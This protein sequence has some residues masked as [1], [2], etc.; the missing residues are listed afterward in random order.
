MINYEIF[1]LLYSEFRH[2]SYDD[3]VVFT[4]QYVVDKL[5]IRIQFLKE[6]NKIDVVECLILL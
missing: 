3:N 4:Q 2:K 5:Q 1:D 6:E